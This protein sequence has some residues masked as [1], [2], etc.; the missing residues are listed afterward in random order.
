MQPLRGVLTALVTPTRGQGQV[1][2]EGT[3]RLLSFQA[4]ARVD[5]VVIGGTTGESPTLSSRELRRLLREALEL[6]P[7]S[8]RVVAGIGKNNF[9]ETLEL[10]RFA[11]DLG[12]QDVM[13]VEPYYNAPSSLE[14]RRE[15][16]SP[17]ARAL[18]EARI[19]VYSIPS[20]TGT[21]IHPIDLA[22][23]HREHA[24]I[25]TLKDACGE[26]A[27]SREVRRL[28][29]RPFSLLSGDD[30]RTLSMMRDPAIAADG[31]ISVASNLAPAAVGAMV[32]AA[33]DGEWTEAARHAESLTPLFQNV[34][35]RVQERTPLGDVGVTS[36]N[37][38]PIKTALSLLGL[39]AGPCRAPLGRL[40]TAGM[41]VLVDSL[42]RVQ[43]A[44]PEVLAPLADQ[45]GVD[46]GARLSDLDLQRGLAYDGY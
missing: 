39:P 30:G 34:T 20:R 6:L 29:P 1:D 4:K 45:F 42:T 25:A 3:R 8:V 9:E 27:Y 46:V 43:N 41:R 35:I 33:L 16:L 38:V 32:R 36:R 23:L 15:F 5:G 40:T 22:M 24:N 10:G 26:D 17:L 13:V 7:S 37:P 14:V 19:I 18:P 31:V 11:H 21:R 44:T 12:V 2:W 28:L